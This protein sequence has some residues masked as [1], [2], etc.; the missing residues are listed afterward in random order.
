MPSQLCPTPYPARPQPAVATHSACSSA[1]AGDSWHRPSECSS[2]PGVA[3]SPGSSSYALAGRA[4]SWHALTCGVDEQ[5]I[6][7][8]QDRFSTAECC[9]A[10]R[11]LAIESLMEGIR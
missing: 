1:R 11:L 4:R 8:R 9:F 7:E 10:G 3:G 5:A 2:V 6:I